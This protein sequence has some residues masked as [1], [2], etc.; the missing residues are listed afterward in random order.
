[1]DH[2]VTLYHH[3]SSACAAKV[4][5]V[6]E[7]KRIA[8]ESCY[9]DIL[10]GG[11]FKPEFLALNPKGVVPVL[12]HDE[13][14]G[15]AVIRESSVI[16]EYLEEAFSDRPHLMPASPRERAAVRIW[17]KA[18]DEELHPACSALTYLASHRHTILA[19]GAGSFEDFLAAPNGQGSSEGRSARELKWRW[20][21]DGFAAPGAA[22]KLRL[23]IAYLDRMEEALARSEWLTGDRFTLADCALTPYV[24]RL[25]ALAMERLWED[26]CRPHVARWFEKVRARP[27]FKPAFLDWMPQDLA[28]EM[29]ANGEASWPQVEQ[30]LATD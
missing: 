29:R 11:Q 8:W 12:A 6:L 18:V 7:E 21:Q 30:V 4:R 22:D 10:A 16:C 13:G 24:N 19:R 28:A 25:C 20:I 3:G 23:Y 15:A 9:V 27:S 14:D 17:T 26:G 5:V 1:M 2:K